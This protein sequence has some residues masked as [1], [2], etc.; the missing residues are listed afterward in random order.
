M[1]PE[2]LPLA[3]R[4]SRQGAGGHAAP[5]INERL[6]DREEDDEGRNHRQPAQRRDRTYS[7]LCYVR[8]IIWFACM[9]KGS[10]PFGS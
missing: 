10:F 9:Q 8:L 4:T 2:R 3:K 7:R 1:H 6:P 5:D